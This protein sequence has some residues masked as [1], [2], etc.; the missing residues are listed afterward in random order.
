[1][2]VDPVYAIFRKNGQKF[3]LDF[4]QLLRKHSKLM[5]VVSLSHR[6]SFLAVFLSTLSRSGYMGVRLTDMDT[7]FLPFL[8]YTGISYGEHEI[9]VD[10]GLVGRAFIGIDARIV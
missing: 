7:T 1:M 6:S 8:S 2:D 5:R 3:S 9:I 10:D 4:H